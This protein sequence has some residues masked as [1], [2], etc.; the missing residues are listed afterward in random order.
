MRLRDAIEDVIRSWDAHERARGGRDVIDY[1]CAPT[2]QAVTPAASRLDVYQRLTEL[3]D[4]ARAEDDDNLADLIAAHR[5]YLSAVLGQRPPLDDYLTQTQG[6]P[7]AGWP[8]EHVVMVGERASN[9]L[10]EVG[11]EWGADTDTQRRKVEQP[12]DAADVREQ[13]RTVAGEFEP[14][15]R[16]LTGSHAPYVVSIETVEVDDY[17]SYWLD[18]AGVDARLRL[19]LRHATFTRTRLRSLALH[20]ILG[21]A[22]QYASYAHACALADVPWPRVLSVHLPYQVLFEGLAQTLPLF[23]AADDPHLTAHVRV[24]HYT[25]L[26]RAELHRAINDGASI[27]DCADH[28]RARV[29]WWTNDTIADALTDRGSDPLL[30]SYLWAYPAGIDWFVAVADTADTDTAGRV[31]RAAY[32]RPLTPRDLADIWPAGP[33]VG[34]PGAPVRLRKPAVP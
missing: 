21:H 34:G 16:E 18:G 11:V 29:P 17:W 10:A 1:D 7:A 5:A 9:A 19:N 6:C 14:A 31:L 26:V 15:V 23:V 28:A 13:I 3:H 25:Q 20:E 30:R 2:D 8:E 4:Q 22:M 12:V 33:T 32:Q 24:D 27:T